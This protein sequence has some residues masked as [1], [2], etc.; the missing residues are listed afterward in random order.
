MTVDTDR[1]QA[2]LL[3]MRQLIGH[4]EGIGPVTAER[5]SDDF[6]LRLQVER[7]LS[8]VVTLATEINLHVVS[9]ELT[10]PPADLRESFEEM[11]EAGWLSEELAGR[12][13]DSPGLRNVLLHEY[14]RIDLTIVA[15]A[16]PMAVDG[17]GEY[18]RAIAS[19][20]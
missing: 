6:G 19:R 2:R 3:S 16:V 13:K 10:R 1:L 18:V 11:V 17:F 4:L 20:L 9:R 14:V 15:S 12:L 7:A 8:Q 5:L